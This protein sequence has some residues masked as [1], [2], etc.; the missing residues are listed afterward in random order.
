[1]INRS[2]EDVIKHNLKKIELAE[3][4]KIQHEISMHKYRQ[5]PKLWL[6]ERLK[7]DA[8][9]LI[10]EDFDKEAYANHN[11]DGTKNP[12]LETWQKI[13]EGKW[14]SL[15]SGTGTGKTYFLARLVLWFLDVFPS[16]LVV[17]SAPKQDQLKLHLWNE[18][19]TCIHKFKKI[20]PQCKLNS[21]DLFVDPRHIDTDDVEVSQRAWMATGFVAGIKAD[22]QSATKAQ[23]FHRENLLIVCEETPGMPWPTLFAFT[24]TAE[25][26]TII[27]AV[28]NPD[29]KIDA[30]STFEE[31]YSRKAHRVRISGLDHPNVVAGMNLIPGATSREGI[32]TKLE[33]ENGNKEG[34]AY[35]SRVRGIAPDQGSD[36]LI[37]LEWVNAA[38]VNPNEVDFKDLDIDNVKSRNAAAAD[39]AN[40]KNG[41]DAGVL[42]GVKNVVKY[43]K[44]FKCANSN[45]IAD[46]MIYGSDGL[47]ADV[48]NNY[49]IP[50]YKDFGILPKYIGVDPV[51]IGAGTVNRF[52]KL[53]HYV[54]SLHGGQDQDCIPYV[55]RKDRDRHKYKDYIS[56]FNSLRA[57]M[58]WQL[59]LDF[60]KGDFIIYISDTNIIREITVQC[61][62]IKYESKS[63]IEIEPKDK[64]KQRLGYSPTHLDLLSYWNWM[65]KDR[66]FKPKKRPF[67]PPI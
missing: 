44:T 15:K 51:G 34:F 65:R 59:R 22:E 29:S 16:S 20:R 54:K 62:A 42:Y 11:W 33:S 61:T 25:T 37:R 49:G 24:N 1:M 9:S 3:I 52:T 66:I 12:F 64:L 27:V 17:T 35:K 5:D 38:I 31:R 23:G 45:E 55:E 60:E 50:S 58:L 39:A 67:V 41:D 46:N 21:L 43:I 30:L 32:A 14:I 36:S 56:R 63:T 47:P 10:W 28:G 40:S 7:E 6:E 48:D 13:V 4:K 2:R 26:G 53:K 18:I 57:Q 8:R 19:N